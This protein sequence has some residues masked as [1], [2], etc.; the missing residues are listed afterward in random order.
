MSDNCA[1]GIVMGRPRGLYLG[2][3]G[4]D[5]PRVRRLRVCPSQTAFCITLDSR[6]VPASVVPCYLV[7]P[8]LIIDR[9][10]RA[11]HIHHH[12]SRVD[13]LGGVRQMNF[14]EWTGL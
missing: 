11:A 8:F 14:L 7:D 9:D 10:C 3:Q 2:E 12:N 1:I 4:P 6:E 5:R 13:S